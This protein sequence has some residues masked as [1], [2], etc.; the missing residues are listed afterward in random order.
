MLKFLKLKKKFF[1]TPPLS[2]I[3]KNKNYHYQIKILILNFLRIFLLMD[4]VQ[5]TNDSTNCSTASEG[6]NSS[7]EQ[8]SS[9]NQGS[10]SGQPQEASYT[11]QTQ[12]LKSSSSTSLTSQEEI[13]YLKQEN[14]ALANK[15]SEFS[16]T[17]VEHEET[18]AQQKKLIEQI[19]E[20]NK[21]FE[22]ILAEQNKEFKQILAEQNKQFEQI[23]AEQNKQFEQILAG[24][25]K[26]EQ[27]LAEKNKLE[28]ILAEKNQAAEK[29]D[30]VAV[31]QQVQQIVVEKEKEIQSLSNLIAQQNTQ[32]QQ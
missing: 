17:I 14:Q 3:I 10:Q 13:Q 23:L 29:N 2:Q 11:N 12:A 7:K 27:I 24:K 28:R 31:N 18:I 25:N 5:M 30:I 9:G 26:L 6:Q 8:L 15:Q 22:Q 4:N 19:L 21:Q 16:K 20:E 32:N 1:R